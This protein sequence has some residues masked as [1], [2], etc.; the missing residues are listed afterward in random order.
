MAMVV[1]IPSMEQMSADFASIGKLVGAPAEMDAGMILSQLPGGAAVDAKGPLT[2]VV[3]ELPTPKPGAAAGQEEEPKAVGLVNGDYGAIVK[4]LGGT[5]TDGIDT[6]KKDGEDLFLK[7]LE[8]NMVAF[9]DDRAT[10]EAF[11]LTT[12]QMASYSKAAGARAESLSKSADMIVSIDVAKAKPTLEAGIKEMEQQIEDMAAMGGGGGAQPNVAAAKWLMDTLVND[13]AGATLFLDMSDAGIGLH[14]VANFKEGSRM[15]KLGA[16]KGVASGLTARLPMGPYLALLGLDLSNA[17]LRK[18]IGEMPQD[19]NAPGAAVQAATNKAM[20]EQTTGTSMMIGVNPGGPMAGVLARSVNYTFTKD[21]AAYIAS[22]Q[23]DLAAAYK[24]D[25]IGTATFKADAADVGGTKVM[26]YDIKLTPSE[27]MPQQAMQIMFGMT[28]GPSGY[29]HPMDGGVITTIGR[30]SDLM[31]AAMKAFGKGEGTIG[32][33]K[34][35]AATSAMLPA[36][37]VAEVY[38]GTKGLLDSLL[39]LAAMFTGTPLNVEVPDDVSP[40]GAAIAPAGDSMQASIVIPTSV[41]K[42]GAAVAKAVREAAP[43][44]DADPMEPAPGGGGGR[45]RF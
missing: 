14:A 40:I 5:A 29:M 15:A 18:L 42:T 24:A 16:V 34:P 17:E 21:P 27:D 2:I 20:L 26:S 9:S 1:V 35:L 13:A 33:N 8:G 25:N 37:R 19:K 22:Q 11:K 30:S 32:D 12:G 10:L 43:Q 39:P 3:P 6:V 41:L 4:E 36:D 28:G 38:I 23:N 44:D 45:P 31:G 7:K